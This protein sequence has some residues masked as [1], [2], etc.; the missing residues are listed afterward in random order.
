M[1]VF[2]KPKS[3]KPVSHLAGDSGG[4]NGGG[5]ANAAGDAARAAAT[6]PAARR[7]TIGGVPSPNWYGASCCPEVG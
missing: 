2:C 5:R 7:H 4:G 6:R 1:Y 3:S